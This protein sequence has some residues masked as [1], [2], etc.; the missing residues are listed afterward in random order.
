MLILNKRSVQARDIINV[1]MSSMKIFKNTGRIIEVLDANDRVTNKHT[2]ICSMSMV[3]EF[4]GGE[5]YKHKIIN[6]L[7]LELRE[8]RSEII[9][10]LLEIC[11]LRGVI[12]G[13]TYNVGSVAVMVEVEVV[14]VVVGISSLLLVVIVVVVCSYLNFRFIIISSSSYNNGSSNGSSSGSSSSSC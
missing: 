7:S 10:E 3:K 13:Y 8:S 2:S 4:N 11:S 14:M 6:L 12:S 9:V 5:I 1:H